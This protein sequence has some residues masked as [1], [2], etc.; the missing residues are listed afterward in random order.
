V[1]DR[2]NIIT[3]IHTVASDCDASSLDAIDEAIRGVC[4]EDTEVRFTECFTTIDRLLRVI[5]DKKGKFGPVRL[6]VTTD[7]MRARS[8]RLP[9]DH[10]AM[11][12]RDPRIALGGELATRTQDVDGQYKK[13][14]E[15][16]AYGGA[17][18][19]DSP[20]GPYFGLQQEQLEELYDS[21]MDDGSNELCTR[22][23][24]EF[25]TRR[26]IAHALSH[27]LDEHQLSC[28]GTFKIISEFAFS[29]TV[30]GGFFASSS[31]IIEAFMRLNNAILDGA[32]ISEELLSDSGRRIIAHIR[33][34]GHH[35]HPLGGS[36]AHLWDFDRTLTT[37]QIPQ[38]KSA[39]EVTPGDLFER[40]LQFTRSPKTLEPFGPQST[41]EIVG[42]PAT[43]F[44]QLLDVL[45]IIALN[46]LRNRRHL[47]NPILLARM[48]TM[49]AVVSTRA[50]RSRAAARRQFRRDLKDGFDPERVLPLLEYP[51]PLGQSMVLPTPPLQEQHGTLP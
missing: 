12:A 34:N 19:V 11:A 45:G 39:E 43:P 36:D 32:T 25:L 8:H 31:R 21:C 15:I 41:L 4:G 51:V 30:N 6:L 37:L 38:G 22:K 26:G 23:A 47:W 50:L 48:L 2:I 10:I 28:E 40:M 44:F 7:H 49:S 46:L 24:R 1:S 13:G 33:S 27:P 18:P 9:P 42:S 29:E 5:T 3:H 17:H 16:L 14:P 20:Q 35:I